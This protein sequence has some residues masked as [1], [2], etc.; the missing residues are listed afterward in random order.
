[1]RKKCKPHKLGEPVSE[2]GPL[3]VPTSQAQDPAGLQ[4]LLNRRDGA[5]TLHATLRGWAP[6]HRPV[7]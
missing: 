6:G 5:L 4:L 7:Q 3:S 1:M 2:K